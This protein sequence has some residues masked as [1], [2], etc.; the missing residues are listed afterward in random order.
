MCL[1]WSANLQAGGIAILRLSGD[2]SLDIANQLFR[3]MGGKQWKQE[4]HRAVYGAIVDPDG[5]T[6]DEVRAAADAVVVGCAFITN[7]NFRL[8]GKPT[9]RNERR[10]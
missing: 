2:E 5:Q 7:L 3:P 10:C 6:L 9:A 8:G 4:S 1:R